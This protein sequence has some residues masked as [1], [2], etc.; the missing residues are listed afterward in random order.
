[1]TAED[2]SLLHDWLN[3]A[4]VRTFYQRHPIDLS[5]IRQKYTSRLQSDSTIHCF[6]IYCDR[7]PIGYI[8]TY[9]VK[10]CPDYAAVIGRK[11]GLC[12]D[13]YIGGR[14]FLKQGLGYLIELKFL[15]EI[16]FQTTSANKCYRL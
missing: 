15:Q 10:D 14:D 8:Q 5:G 4:H 11:D 2:F 16:A 3:Q 13:L 6:I 1:M 7:I 12:I 9:L